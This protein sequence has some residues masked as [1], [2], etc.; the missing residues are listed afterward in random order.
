MFQHC[1]SK[2]SQHIFQNYCFQTKN[3]SMCSP[4][5][6]KYFFH[7]F[8][9]FFNCPPTVVGKRKADK[10]CQRSLS[11]M[12]KIFPKR[13]GET[14]RWSFYGAKRKV[15]I[16]TGGSPSVR[17]DFRSQI[18]PFTDSIKKPIKPA[19]IQ[20]KIQA[21]QSGCDTIFKICFKTFFH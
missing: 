17:L 5:I 2:H 7:F 11:V 20:F 1:F 13:S 4:N 14:P 19:I 18:F 9:I 15:D 21:S 12:L 6:C 10:A 16:R 3:V 8:S